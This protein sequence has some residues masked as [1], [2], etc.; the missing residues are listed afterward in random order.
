MKKQGNI[1][2]RVLPALVLLLCLSPLTVW[3]AE[4]NAR[5]V[6]IFKTEGD[7]VKM[8]KGTAAEFK[9]KE[10][11]KLYDG[12]TLSTGK[13]SYAYLK[14]DED[15][16]VKVDQQS[17]IAV[18]KTS[19]DKLSLSVQSGSALV[20]AG[21]QEAGQVIETRAGNAGLTI[22]GTVF[23]I[24]QSENGQ[25]AI[26]M[27]SGSGEVDGVPLPAGYTMLVYDDGALADTA[28]GIIEANIA[29]MDLLTLL[30]VW[31]YREMLTESGI[32][33]E[34]MLEAVP[35]LI[36]EKITERENIPPS[37]VIAPEVVRTETAP[38]P[39]PAP[40][41]APS[42]APTP[43]P[44][45]RPTNR[46]SGS[47][48]S[49][50]GNTGSTPNPTPIPP[51]TPDTSNS[52]FKNVTIIGPFHIMLSF[53]HMISPAEFNDIIDRFSM[54]V[55]GVIYTLPF[56]HTEGDSGAL[57]SIVLQ[58]VDDN[59]PLSENTHT[60]VCSMEGE[61]SATFTRTWNSPRELS[62]DE[63]SADGDNLYLDL[64]ALPSDPW[65]GSVTVL[66][67]D[68]ELE[69][70]FIFGIESIDYSAADDRMTIY[71]FYPQDYPGKT[72]VLYSYGLG[73]QRSW[74]FT[75]PEA[76]LTAL[77][78][79]FFQA[80]WPGLIYVKFSDVI[81]AVE[82]NTM[83]DSLEVVV[84]TTSYIPNE[85]IGMIDAPGLY[86]GVCLFLSADIPM[87]NYNGK[88]L[89][90]TSDVFD[91]TLLGQYNN[92]MPEPSVT[93]ASVSGNTLTVPVTG[94]PFSNP[95]TEVYLLLQMTSTGDLW[96]FTALQAEFAYDGANN[97]DIIFYIDNLPAMSGYQA[98][99][100]SAE[101][102]T[103]WEFVLP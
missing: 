38:S 74:R 101:F 55:D 24:G 36:Q 100:Y 42:T 49:G 22:R 84:D 33:T 48:G 45:P 28:Y 67:E 56:G 15:S 81:P 27:L 6:V 66:S 78:F 89:T 17:L 1:I 37:P 30:A 99:L 68:G 44:T 87:S 43:R 65:F 47:G 39:A 62:A 54:T 95:S 93:A 7:N 10:G 69:T 90:L 2:R 91:D 51:L 52:L 23:I 3:A 76:E 59:K 26:T 20:D 19:K 57:D 103:A 9:A 73:W 11:Y 61:A 86:N 41:P 79:D 8:T 92:Q 21:K 58:I 75:V 97:T 64:G 18:S 72:V 102:K 4:R 14:L 5:T 85:Y 32:I 63:V 35:D 94:T 40:T 83:M 29:E 77:S 50:A 98:F 70:Q 88:N 71:N 31:E 13:D 16:V 60:F 82:F 12:Y 96:D 53:S 34:E 25:V 80:F 46:P